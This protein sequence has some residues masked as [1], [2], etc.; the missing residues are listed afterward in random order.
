M[1]LTVRLFC[2]PEVRSRAPV[3]P[4]RGRPMNGDPETVNFSGDANF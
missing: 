4:L 2:Q 3:L 1:D